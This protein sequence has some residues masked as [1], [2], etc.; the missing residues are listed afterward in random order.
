MTK[1]NTSTPQKM[2][3]TE[4]KNGK[5]GSKCQKK[6]ESIWRRRFVGVQIVSVIFH[7][8]E[9]VF[10]FNDGLYV[11]IISIIVVCCIQDI[12]SFVN[13]IKHQEKTC[14]RQPGQPEST[15]EEGPLYRIHDETRTKIGSI[16]RWLVQFHVHKEW[17]IEAHLWQE[18]PSHSRRATNFPSG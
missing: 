13:D 4:K 6:T 7:H 10:L 18:S 3:A 14:L 9:R 16:W 8:I 12:I 2:T 17:I 15:Q 11:G 5:S 1:K